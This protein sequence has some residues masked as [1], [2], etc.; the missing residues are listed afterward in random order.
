MRLRL[1][2]STNLRSLSHGGNGNQDGQNV[3]KH[4][5]GDDHDAKDDK[6]Y[7]SETNKEGEEVDAVTAV[8][9]QHTSAAAS[10]T[11]TIIT[12]MEEIF[13]RLGFTQTVAQKLADD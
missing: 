3:L 11:P 13:L 4:P 8:H 2:R 6:K 5:F 9:G 10:L 1:T 12:E 7:L